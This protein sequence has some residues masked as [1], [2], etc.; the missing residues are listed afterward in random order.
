M[1]LFILAACQ[2]SPEGQGQAV[3]ASQNPTLTP[4]P[5]LTNTPEPTPTP[6]VSYRINTNLPIMGYRETAKKTDQLE[7]QFSTIT[8]EDFSSGKLLEF[9]LD[10]ISQNPVFTDEVNNN[11]ITLDRFHAEGVLGTFE[12]HF[13]DIVT[14]YQNNPATRPIKIISYYVF[15]DEKFFE[16]MGIHPMEIASWVDGGWPFWMVTWAYHNPDGE[17]VLGHSLVDIFSHNECLYSL[18]IGRYSPPNS[19]YRPTPIFKYSDIKMDEADINRISDLAVYRIYQ[20]YPEFQPDEAM[21]KD[22]IKTQEMSK[23]L[24]TKL[25]SLSWHSSRWT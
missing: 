14:D 24:Q 6:E 5:T 10:Y 19:E 25:F 20:E 15:K 3:T 23:E 21:V 22:W 18:K 4:E 16:N 1:V 12:K 17:T 8:W 7:R 2:P 13:V 9:E 11:G